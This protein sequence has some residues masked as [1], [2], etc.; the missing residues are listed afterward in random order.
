MLI[1]EVIEPT[2]SKLSVPNSM[3]DI[4]VTHV[5]LDGTSILLVVRQ[6]E[7]R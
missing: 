6:F 4:F 2:S 7:T 1:P 3:L 5:M